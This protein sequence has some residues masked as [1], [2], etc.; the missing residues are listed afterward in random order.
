M[1]KIIRKLGKIF[2]H[3][4][5]FFDKWLITPI[6]KF[7]LIVVDIFKDNSKSVDKFLSKK[8][9]LIVISLVLAFGVFL[10][11]DNESTVMIDQ[12]AE[13]LY[14]QSVNFMEKNKNHN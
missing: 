6:T 9:T 11:I 13:I 5:S 7:I 8:S 1:K 3:I 14:N 12:Y 10:I 2:H 4:G